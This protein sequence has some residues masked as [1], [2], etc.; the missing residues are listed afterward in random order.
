MP[1]RGP[2]LEGSG[3]GRVALRRAF[4]GGFEVRGDACKA[5][6]KEGMRH[7]R[8]RYRMRRRAGGVRAGIRRGELRA[9]AA[10]DGAFSGG[11]RAGK[12]RASDGG[13]FH[14]RHRGAGARRQRRAGCPTRR[15]RRTRS[16]RAGVSGRPR[17]AFARY[18]H[19]ARRRPGLRAALRAHGPTRS[20]SVAI[21]R[22]RRNVLPR[23][24]L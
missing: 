20:R 7:G 2:A 1:A 21:W 5:S 17:G 13:V 12:Q 23:C 15:T 24:A 22:L 8:G 11:A 19:A 4:R 16:A 10:L 18:P 6:A 9:R 14:A 3:A